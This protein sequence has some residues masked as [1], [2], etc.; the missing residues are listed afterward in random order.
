M[1]GFCGDKSPQKLEEYFENEDNDCAKKQGACWW[2]PLFILDYVVVVILFVLAL[3]FKLVVEPYRMFVPTVNITTALLD[4]EGVPH[5]VVQTIDITQDRQYPAVPEV[6]PTVRAGIVFVGVCVLSWGLSQLVIRSLTSRKWNPLHDFH[7]TV[8]G[9]LESCGIELFF[10]NIL[11]PF[12]G[13]YRPR[14][15]AIAAAAG[16]NAR[17]EWEGR[18]SYPSG[19]TGTSF[20]ALFFCTLYLLGKTRVYSR[21]SRFGGGSAGRFGIIMICL[22][23]TLVAYLIAITRTRDYMHNF[24]D[25]NGGAILGILSSILAY[26]IVFPSLTDVECQ[27]P[28]IRLTR[29][30]TVSSAS[31][32][33]VPPPP[34]KN[35]SVD[36]DVVVVV[37]ADREVDSNLAAS[38]KE[39]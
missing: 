6:L 27:L 9:I 25:V 7:N 23:P 39:D 32:S 28:R 37:N 38:S 3:V 2:S 36:D 30:T 18:V 4:S 33:P 35:D 21:S 15:L 26:F 5:N 20:A 1:G 14:Y 17:K 19:H 29:M 11:K 12:A 8:L 22:I 13:R 31:G 34:N 24:S 16:S 10:C